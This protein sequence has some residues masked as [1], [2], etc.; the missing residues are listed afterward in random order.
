M[1]TRRVKAYSSSCSQTLSLSSHFITTF[2]GGTAIWCP[3]AQVSLNLE[4]WDLDSRNLRTMLK[5]LYTACPRLSQLLS[6][7]FALKM[8]LAAQ[9]RQKIHKNHYFSVQGHLR[10]LNFQWQSRANVR[11]PIILSH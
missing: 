10:S 4:N 1:L 2:T 9:N 7:Q 5:I 8:C 11:L 3:R 6:A